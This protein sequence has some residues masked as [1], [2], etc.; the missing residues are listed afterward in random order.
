MALAGRELSA[1]MG[2]AQMM[3]Y[4][5][6]FC[7]FALSLILTRLGWSRAKTA[8]PARHAMRN[9]V[10]F[11]AQFGW[12]YAIA[13]IPIAQVFAIEFTTPI[14]T[15]VIAAFFLG[16][17]MTKARVAAIALGF[18]GTL[19]ILRPGVADLDPAALVALAAAFGFAITHAFTR[20]LVQKD[21]AVAVITWMNAM[22]LPIAFALALPYW[23]DPLPHQWP[24]IAAMSVTGLGS[25]YFLS[26]AFQYGEATT[27]ATIDF[28]RLPLA[29]AVAW[30][31]Y[32][33]KVDAPVF[34]GAA[35]IF[36]G[37][38]LNLRK[39]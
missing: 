34:V 24:W 15:A 13:R 7:V 39:A 25:H 19:V 21:G 33:E 35:I 36:L 4:R 5:N 38:W 22:Q 30:L 37:V 26:K 31:L 32:T 6:V 11:A 2:P 1:T 18:V 17:R 16:E 8:K 10:H 3:F 12:F 14:W 9:L 20:D 23:A 28:L 29:A 27:V